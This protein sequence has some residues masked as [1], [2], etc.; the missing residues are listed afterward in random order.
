MVSVLG[1]VAVKGTKRAALRAGSERSLV[2][3]KISSM[4]VTELT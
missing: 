1:A 3:A 2:E 4:G